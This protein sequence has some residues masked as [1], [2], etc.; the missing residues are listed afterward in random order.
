MVVSLK[1]EVPGL[2]TSVFSKILSASS[3][4]LPGEG[5][6]TQAHRAGIGETAFLVAVAEPLEHALGLVEIAEL[7]QDVAGNGEQGRAE[8]RRIVGVD[9]GD[10]LEIE[11]G[12]VGA[13]QHLGEP[14]AGVVEAGVGRRVF[15][16]GDRFVENFDELLVEGVQIDLGRLFAGNDGFHQLVDEELDLLGGG[17]GDA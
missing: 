8:D 2:L 7:Q 6:V 17:I 9:G 15:L 1:R 16:T 12:P 10:A 4:L 13:F 14:G 3:G 5:D 11:L